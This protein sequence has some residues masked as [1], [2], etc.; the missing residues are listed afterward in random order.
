VVKRVAEAAKYFPELTSLLDSLVDYSLCER[1]YNQVVVRDSFIN[2][3][4]EAKTIF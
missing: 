1:H 4:T 2:Q 3:L